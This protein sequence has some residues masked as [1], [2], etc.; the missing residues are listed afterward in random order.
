MERGVIPSPGNIGYSKSKLCHFSKVHHLF[1]L[2]FLSRL[3][4]STQQQ[5]LPPIRPQHP[6]QIRHRLMLSNLRQ[7][8]FIPLQSHHK[9]IHVGVLHALIGFELQFEPEIGTDL[10]SFALEESECF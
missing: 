10:R 9:C 5:L 8:R 6:C 3:K 4:T 1:I 2:L 7:I